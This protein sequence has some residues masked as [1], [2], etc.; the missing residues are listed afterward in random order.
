MSNVYGLSDEL[1]KAARLVMEKKSLDPVGKEDDDVDN[2]GDSDESDEY[3]KN[4]RKKV[5]KKVDDDKEDCDEETLDE[6][7][8]RV[9]AVSTDGENFK[10]GLLDKKSADDMHYKM[11]QAKNK[12]GTAA[13]K[14]I[15]VAK[16]GTLSMIKGQPAR[17]PVRTA[18]P[19]T[20]ILGTRG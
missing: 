17:A 6:K 1:I 3:L 2:D 5:S 16:E 9:H 13:Y 19:A 20:R 10:S 4:R 11:T 14:T 7:T 12:K 8:Y 15:A 18:A